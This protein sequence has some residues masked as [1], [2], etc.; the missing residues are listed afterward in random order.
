MLSIY[1]NLNLNKQSSKGETVLHVAVKSGCVKTVKLLL[2]AGA[3]INVQDVMLLYSFV[4][5]IG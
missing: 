5:S 2:K 4:F 1:P 3:D